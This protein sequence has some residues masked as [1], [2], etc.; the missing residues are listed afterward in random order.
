MTP[1]HVS[2][3]AGD[4]LLV[5]AIGDG[6]LLPRKYDANSSCNVILHCIALNQWRVHLNES[7]VNL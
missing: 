6:H 3:I 4:R 2:A 5:A 7:N 1:R